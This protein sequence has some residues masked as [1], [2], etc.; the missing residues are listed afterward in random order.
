MRTGEGDGRRG[1]R[2]GRQGPGRVR[3]VGGGGLASSIASADGVVS[4]ADS[5]VKPLERSLLLLGVARL[6]HTTRS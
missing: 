2:Y 4:A 3:Q 5:S 1:G 6:P